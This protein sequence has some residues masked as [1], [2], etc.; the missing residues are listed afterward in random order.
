V[1]DGIVLTN[2]SGTAIDLNV[3]AR[4]ALTTTDGHLD[5]QPAAEEP[6]G[7]GAWITIETP[8]V[9]IGPGESVTV[10]FTVEIPADAAPGDFG[11]GILTSLAQDDGEGTVA[12]DRRLALRAFVRVGGQLLPGVAV[13]DVN[14][15][16]TTTLNPLGTTTATVR[17]VIVNTG[18]AR[19][20]PT[21]SV[22]VTGPFGWFPVTA[23][24]W[25][26]EEILPGS[27]IVQDFEIATVR[28]L[29]RLTATIE[30]TAAAVGVG[31]VGL[32]TH[33]TAAATTWLIPWTLLAAL[34]L[35]G[36]G[37]W[38]AAR[39]LRRPRSSPR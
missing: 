8:S 6:V 26:G 20:V 38:L 33:T 35:V 16:A 9:R 25:E 10:P 11:G 2:R 30:V 14:L 32:S 28:S 17:A 1:S 19:L 36:L 39:H 13:Q 24:T 29:G 18:N 4:D 31:G 23:P 15:N 5:L 34:I 3:Y 27:A 12:V 21:V 22:H 7:L 37:A